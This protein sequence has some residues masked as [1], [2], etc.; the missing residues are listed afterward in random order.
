MLERSASE[1][2]Q[3]RK[4]ADRDFLGGFGAD[5]DA[6]G[7]GDAVTE[8]GA[9]CGQMGEHFGDALA[10]AH[11]ADEFGLTGGEALEAGEVGVPVAVEQDGVHASRRV[12]AAGDRIEVVVHPQSVIHSL[13]EYVDGSVLAQ[14]GNPDMRTP[15][16]HAMA[17]PERVESG[18]GSLSLFDVARL[19]FERPD[20][21]R[22]PCLGLAFRAL[23]AGG[24]APAVLNAANEVAVAAFL[25]GELDFPGIP[26]L[27]AATL[28]ALPA[29]PLQTLDEVL[30]ADASARDTARQLLAELTRP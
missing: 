23:R 29:Q 11:H 16:A 28:D 13:V 12:D 21:E 9:T 3:L 10:A 26:V 18:V 24:S 30:S 14:L 7:S 20:V 27:V 17:F 2:H 6:N 4:D 8:V 1:C 15:I 5:V 25:D 19:D 22:F